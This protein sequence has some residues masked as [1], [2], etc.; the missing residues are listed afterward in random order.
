MNLRIEQ[1]KDNAIALESDIRDL[2][3]KASGLTQENSDLQL[4]VDLLNTRYQDFKHMT[5]EEQ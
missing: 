4:R 2:R 3:E 1:I 5:R